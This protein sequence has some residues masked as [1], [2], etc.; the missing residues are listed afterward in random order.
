MVHYVHT[1]YNQQLNDWLRN[2]PGRVITHYQVA[3]IFKVAYNKAGTI[4][5]SEKKFSST[6]IY[7]PF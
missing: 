1:M 7:L 2:H 3:G 6:E 5:N 4:E